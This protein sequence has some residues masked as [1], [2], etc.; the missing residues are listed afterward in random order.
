MQ[1]E[2]DIL[3]QSFEIKVKNIEKGLYLEQYKK[4]NDIRVVKELMA[5]NYFLDYFLEHPNPNIRVLLTK[6]DYG[7]PTLLK[8]PIPAI[9]MAV[10]K[11]N[12][13]LDILKNDPDW[14]VRMTVA[15]QGYKPSEML[16]DSH[17]CVKQAVYELLLKNQKK[18][19]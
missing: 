14:M 10:A 8:D 13:G 4:D 19:N 16:K 17:I 9:R 3:A 12:Y 6:L 18:K 15:K 5:R 1:N 2:L 7:L 11:R